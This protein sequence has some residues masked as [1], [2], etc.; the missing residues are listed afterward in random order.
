MHSP[1]TP[2]GVIPVGRDGLGYAAKVCP[3]P[4]VYGTYAPI[5]K[6]VLAEVSL[7]CEQ[8]ERLFIF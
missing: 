3:Y 1:A 2:T 4:G 8:Q 5:G 6:S 7:H